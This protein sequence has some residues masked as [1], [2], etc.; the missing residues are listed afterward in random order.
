MA[1]VIFSSRKISVF[2]KFSQTIIIIYERCFCDLE[3][4]NLL[5]D[6]FQRKSKQFTILHQDITLNTFPI[7]Q[8]KRHLYNFCVM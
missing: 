5:K 8:Q 3:Q 7:K 4:Q 6:I 2:P 1:A